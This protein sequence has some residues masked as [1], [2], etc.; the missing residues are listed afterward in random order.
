MLIRSVQT[1]KESF[2]TGHM[3]MGI[4]IV[5]YLAYY[6]IVKYVSPQYFHCR[7]TSFRYMRIREKF[8][9]GGNTIT[10]LIFDQLI[11]EIDNME[12]Q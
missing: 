2:N 10:L 8:V 6:S 11:K 1:R 12:L 9:K 4:A 7:I 3:Q 5:R